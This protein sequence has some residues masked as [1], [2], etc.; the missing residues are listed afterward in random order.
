MKTSTEMEAN[1][2]YGGTE[3]GDVYMEL[4]SDQLAEQAAE[5]AAETAWLRYAERPDFEDESY[6]A[7]W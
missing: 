3:R 7:S 2:Q 1:A 4:T 6:F 5:M